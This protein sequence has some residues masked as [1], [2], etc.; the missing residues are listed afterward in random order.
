MPQ[1]LS[2]TTTVLSQPRDRQPMLG[3]VVVDELVD[4][5]VSGR[6]APG[7]ALPPEGPLSEQFG[8]SRTVVRE[9]VKRIEEKGLVTIARGA[10]PKCAP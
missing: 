2:R 9:S 5:I 8:V 10:A 4:A 7:D 1:P 3:V 6:L